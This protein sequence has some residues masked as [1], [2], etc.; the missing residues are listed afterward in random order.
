MA[1]LKAAITA[2]EEPLLESA[3]KT[4]QQA[5][6]SVWDGALRIRMAQKLQE[7]LKAGRSLQEHLRGCHHLNICRQRLQSAISV[8]WL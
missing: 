5:K 6:H 1:A 2:E 4:L 3:D 7:G 8:R